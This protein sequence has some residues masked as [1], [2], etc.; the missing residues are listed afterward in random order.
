MRIHIFVVLI[1]AFSSTPFAACYT[2]YDKSDKPV[3]KSS[4][5]PFDLSIPISEGI[6]SKYPGGYLIQSSERETCYLRSNKSSEAFKNRR[7]Q[8]QSQGFSEVRSDRVSILPFPKKV[9]VVARPLNAPTFPVT[10]GEMVIGEIM[11]GSTIPIVQSRSVIGGSLN[12]SIMP[13]SEDEMTT[14]V[15]MVSSIMQKQPSEMA[16]IKPLGGSLMTGS[17]SFDRDSYRQN[18]NRFDAETYRQ[19][20]NRFDAETYRQNTN[21][22]DRETYRQNTNPFD[23]ETY[24]QNT[25]PFDRETYRQGPFQ[26][27]QSN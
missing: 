9:M 2:V 12:G 1:L 10:Q 22:F 6:K 15:P 19:N 13:D 18:T 7:I 17:N 5:P 23:R 24:R 20:T 27:G 14:G 4:E 26:Y 16:I 3:Y 11:N 8:L 25:N 21:R